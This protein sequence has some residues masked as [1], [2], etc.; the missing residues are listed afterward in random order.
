MLTLFSSSEVKSARADPFPPTSAL[1]PHSLSFKSTTSGSE[2]S[3]LNSG[4]FNMG[5]ETKGEAGHGPEYL[6][7]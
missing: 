1:M 2:D 5:N 6:P 4:S 3:G 7:K